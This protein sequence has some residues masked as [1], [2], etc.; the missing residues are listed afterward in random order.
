MSHLLSTG[1]LNH[2]EVL[3]DALGGVLDNLATFAHSRKVLVLVLVLVL[4]GGLLHL[5]RRFSRGRGSLWLDGRSVVTFE[6]FRVL[7]R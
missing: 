4:I 6:T 2:L 3:I 5:L 7:D 1:F